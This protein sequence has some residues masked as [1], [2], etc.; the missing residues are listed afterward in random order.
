MASGNNE[1]QTAPETV[2][3]Y[4]SEPNNEANYTP[5]ELAAMAEQVNEDN[6]RFEEQQRAIQQAA[7]EGRFAQKRATRILRGLPGRAS[8][9]A[10]AKGRVNTR[11]K[12]AVRNAAIRNK[13][14][15]ARQQ[16]KRNVNNT[17][18]IFEMS[19]LQN[20]QNM[21]PEEQP[22]ALE[23][24][25]AQKN[26]FKEEAIAQIRRTLQNAALAQNARLYSEAKVGLA[27][28]NYKNAKYRPVVLKIAALDDLAVRE[29]EKLVLAN[30]NEKAREAATRLYNI[31]LLRDEIDTARHQSKLPTPE[32]NA[33]YNA[34]VT[35]FNF[36][37]MPTSIYRRLAQNNANLS[38]KNKAATKIQALVR[39]MKGRKNARTRRAIRNLARVAVNEAAPMVPINMLAPPKPQGQLVG[40]P[41]AANA[42]PLTPAQM[43]AARLA[44][45]EKRGLGGK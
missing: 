34:L 42:A 27:S 1:P 38:R 7:R 25:P 17:A 12:A 36:N 21:S 4:N 8:W 29:R 5:E 22:L 20:I 24:L 31:E 16:F 41:G 35:G 23:M 18:N 14:R 15:T 28:Y 9:V 39:G 30:T 10:R 33:R 26:S 19:A 45:L 44:A 11:R 40:G 43:R 6:R 37:S 32:Q 13:A 3:H 2:Y